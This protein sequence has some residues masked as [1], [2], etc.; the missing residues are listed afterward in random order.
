MSV[1]V[2]L[3]ATSNGSEADG[4]NGCR[5]LRLRGRTNSTEGLAFTGDES[6]ILL[7][8]RELS[9]DVL[10]GLTQACGRTHMTA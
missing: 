4:T 10:L 1:S 6:D 8:C 9:R 3:F 2:M 7:A 5:R